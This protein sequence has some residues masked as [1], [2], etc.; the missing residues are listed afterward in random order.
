[1]YGKTNILYWNL[2]RNLRDYI[3]CNLPEMREKTA[4][5]LLIERANMTLEA[6]CFS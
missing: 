2:T 5:K 3:T 4:L 6:R 1:M